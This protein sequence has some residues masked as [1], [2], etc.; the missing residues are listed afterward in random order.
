MSNTSHTS[1]ENNRSPPH[2]QSVPSS[3]KQCDSTTLAEVALPPATP[4]FP[5]IIVAN[6]KQDLNS[7]HEP[8]AGLIN[9]T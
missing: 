1:N 2:T 4:S 3:P 6:Y 8:I 5:L 7:D 9:L